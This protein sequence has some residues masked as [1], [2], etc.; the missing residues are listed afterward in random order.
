[1]RI[2]CEIPAFVDRL[3]YV[4]TYE[5]NKKREKERVVEAGKKRRD[6]E[7]G[8]CTGRPRCVFVYAT[9]AE[10]EEEEEEKGGEGGE[11]EAEV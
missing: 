5:A 3:P 6:K 1:M 9:A 8:Q 11:G 10:E 7:K 4:R 2:A